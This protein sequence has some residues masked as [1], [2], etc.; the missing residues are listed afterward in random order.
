MFGHYLVR[1]QMVGAAYCVKFYRICWFR[2]VPSQSRLG[3]AAGSELVRNWVRGK[4]AIRDWSVLRALREPAASLPRVPRRSSSFWPGLDLLTGATAYMELVRGWL[5]MA[6]G[7]EPW[8]FVSSCAHYVR[9]SRRAALTA[10]QP[11][12]CAPNFF[13]LTLIVTVLAYWVTN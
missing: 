9:F 4:Y 2:P 10:Y 3:V 7:A 1:N 13:P 6:H 12:L 5:A 8:G 11:A